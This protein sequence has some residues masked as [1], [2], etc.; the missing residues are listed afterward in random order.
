MNH[1]RR[2]IKI[3]TVENQLHCDLCGNVII[4]S[5][6][7]L[8]SDA[9]KMIYHRALCDIGFTFSHYMKKHMNLHPVENSYKCALCGKLFISTNHKQRH[10]KSHAG[11]NPYLCALCNHKLISRNYQQRH[12]KGHLWIIHIHVLCV[13]K[14]SSSSTT[15]RDT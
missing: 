6:Y 10:M 13:S 4:I 7:H 11:D 12:M 2:H 5:R 8:K 15:K 9:S 14:N 3:P 1:I